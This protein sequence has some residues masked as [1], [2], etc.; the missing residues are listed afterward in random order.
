MQAFFKSSVLPAHDFQSLIN[1][2]LPDIDIRETRI[3]FRVVA[4]DLI[5]G[6]KIVFSEGSL[7][8]TVLAS[9]SVPGALAPVRWGDWLLADGGITSLVPVTT[10]RETGADVVI[11][12]M[13]DRDLCTDVSIETAKDVLLRAGEITTNTLEALELADA[14][15][16]IRPQVGH[17]HWMDFTKSAE[18]VK[19][20]EEA[21]RESLH[22]SGICLPLH[23][24]ILRYAQRLVTKR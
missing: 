19:M 15:I 3:P 22:K 13:V 9:C 21:A 5:T 10:A 11:A 20:G 2:F 6:K 24:R 17:L 14:D 16:I 23:R 4:T 8:Q 7:R 1:Y 12:V 18:L